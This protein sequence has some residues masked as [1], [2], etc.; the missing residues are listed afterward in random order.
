MNDENIVS[1]EITGPE[2][3]HTQTDFADDEWMTID[4]AAEHFGCPAARV[5]EWIAS[6]VLT[7]QPSGSIERIKRSELGRVG[8]PD[9]GAA[10]EFEKDHGA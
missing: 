10:Q 9:A 3:A 8:N 7:T 1:G 4:Q 5:R 2:D 6:G